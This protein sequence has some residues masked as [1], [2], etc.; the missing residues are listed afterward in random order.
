M[1]I[2]ISVEW[3][4]NQITTTPIGMFE[5]K[6]D[7]IKRVEQCKE[8]LAELFPDP[9]YVDEDELGYYFEGYDGYVNEV[10]AFEFDNK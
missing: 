2:I 7:A 3:C 6:E 9:E 10:N 5:T 1:Y 4:E 8:S